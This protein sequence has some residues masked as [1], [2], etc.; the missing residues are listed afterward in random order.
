MN[1]IDSLFCS[2][3]NN[4]SIHLAFTHCIVLTRITTIFKFSS[5]IIHTIIKQTYIKIRKSITNVVV[6]K[7]NSSRR[8]FSIILFF[9]MSTIQKVM[10]LPE[11]RKGY[12][13]L[14]NTSRT[15]RNSSTFLTQHIY[16]IILFYEQFL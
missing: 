3:R 4:E 15:L 1:E 8:A 13:R 2:Y 12:K 16:F 5:G 9:K 11:N 7:I 6:V 14:A 10:L